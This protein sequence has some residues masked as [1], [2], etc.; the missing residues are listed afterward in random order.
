MFAIS[1]VLKPAVRVVTDW[2]IEFPIFQ[3]IPYVASY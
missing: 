3:L 1:I 2:K